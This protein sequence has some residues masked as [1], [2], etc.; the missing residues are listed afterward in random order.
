MNL[1]AVKHIPMSQ[2]AHGL[3][4]SHVVFRLRAGR[5]DLKACTLYYADRSCR[6]TPVFFPVLRCRWKRRTNGSITIR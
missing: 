4:P 6:V 1:Q 2:D 5:G 3:D